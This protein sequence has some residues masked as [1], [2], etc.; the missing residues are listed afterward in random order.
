MCI[1][2]NQKQKRKWQKAT[3]R[4]EETKN[5]PK[6]SRYLKVVAELTKRKDEKWERNRRNKEKKEV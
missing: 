6:A 3:A 2:M 5:T 1:Q 4:V